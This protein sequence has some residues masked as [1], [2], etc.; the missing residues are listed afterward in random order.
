[1]A[2]NVVRVPLLLFISTRPFHKHMRTDNLHLETLYFQ[3]RKNNIF[4]KYRARI[5]GL[6]GKYMN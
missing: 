4:L 5:H 2:V 3:M 1:M 6:R